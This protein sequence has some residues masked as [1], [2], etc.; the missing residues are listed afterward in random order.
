M[1]DWIKQFIA[2]IKIRLIAFSVIKVS[3]HPDTYEL[4]FMQHQDKQKF[5][6]MDYR[7]WLRAISSPNFKTSLILN[8]TL[9]K[10]YMIT[11]TPGTA[12]FCEVAPENLEKL[13]E[14]VTEEC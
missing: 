1:F 14:N 11:N 8:A 2:R 4:T 12:G 3:K 10:C 5:K 13:L 7:D 9:Q 6:P